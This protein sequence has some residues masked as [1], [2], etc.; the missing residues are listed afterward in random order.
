MTIDFEN[1]PDYISLLAEVRENFSIMIPEERKVRLTQ[2]EETM[3]S[4]FEDDSLGM[5]MAKKILQ[6]AKDLDAELTAK[7]HGGV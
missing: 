6:Y 1:D 7:I 5:A 4:T 2:M 3:P